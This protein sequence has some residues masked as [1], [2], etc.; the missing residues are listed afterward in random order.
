M[1]AARSDDPPNDPAAVKA[2]FGR[3]D[4]S[5]ENDDVYM[6]NHDCPALCTEIGSLRM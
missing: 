4:S 3:V 5:D 2:N 1:S 6:D